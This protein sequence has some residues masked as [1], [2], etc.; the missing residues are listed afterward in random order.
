MLLKI[1]VAQLN[2][3]VGDMTGNARKIIDAL[4]PFVNIV[5]I[6]MQE[7]RLPS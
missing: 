5:L 6:V 1:C 7:S 3:V 2:Y 4:P